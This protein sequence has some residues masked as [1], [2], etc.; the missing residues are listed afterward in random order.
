MEKIRIDKQYEHMIY[1]VMDV[2]A[3]KYEDESF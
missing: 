2:R 3:M 1:E